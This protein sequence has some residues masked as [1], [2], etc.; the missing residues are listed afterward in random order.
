MEKEKKLEEPSE[1][2][3]VEESDQSKREFITKLV[4][5]AG[6]LA[7]AGLVAGAASEPAEG[8]IRLQKPDKSGTGTSL[9]KW[10]RHMNG[11]RLTMSGPDL[12]RGLQ[13]VGIIDDGRNLSKAQ[14]TIEFTY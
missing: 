6:A 2:V 11:F 14:L 9:M 4:T 5:T 13:Q 12:G 10:D 8:A 1:E 3:A 7:A